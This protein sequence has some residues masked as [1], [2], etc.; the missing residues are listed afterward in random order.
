[1]FLNVTLNDHGHA[2]RA[3]GCRQPLRDACKSGQP[4]NQ[5]VVA[6]MD[7]EAERRRRWEEHCHRMAEAT[8]AIAD[9]C[10]DVTMM[11]AYLDLAAKWLRMAREMPPARKEH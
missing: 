10:E 5:V 6:N 7:L 9:W 11:T 3:H 8:H 2:P 4:T 1:M